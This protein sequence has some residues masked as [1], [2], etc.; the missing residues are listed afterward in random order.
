M[1]SVLLIRLGFVAVIL[2]SAFVGYSYGQEDSSSAQ[3][4]IPSQKIETSYKHALPIPDLATGQSGNAKYRLRAS[5]HDEPTQ[6]EIHTRDTDIFYVTSGEAT[7]VAGGKAVSAK[8]TAPNELRGTGIDG[9]TTYH[10]KKGDIMIIPHGIPHW[11]QKIPSA[12]S[13]FLYVE[14]KVQ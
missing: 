1:R 6:V 8:E 13:P 5:R 12:P 11:F 2:A 14:V 7:F 10:L 9:G 3:L 4:Y